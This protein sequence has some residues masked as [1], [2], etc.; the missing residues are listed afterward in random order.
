MT[1]R[2]Q[3]VAG[4]TVGVWGDPADQ[5]PVL[6]LHG[7]TAILFQPRYAAA[8]AHALQNGAS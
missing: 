3:E 2:R 4:L 6:A 8:V 1:Y 7:I 5:H